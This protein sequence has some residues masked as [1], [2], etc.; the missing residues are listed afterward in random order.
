VPEVVLMLFAKEFVAG[1]MGL[2]QKLGFES[3]IH[4]E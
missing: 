2:M 3:E 1:L 4:I